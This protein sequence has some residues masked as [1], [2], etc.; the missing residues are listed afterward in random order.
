VECSLFVAAKTHP[1]L[2]RWFHRYVIF[3]VIYT[4]VSVL[5]I[6]YLFATPAAPTA[7]PV[8]LTATPVPPTATPAPP[9]AITL[10][11]DVIL[12]ITPP[13]DSQQGQCNW[14]QSNFP[15]TEDQAR[16][17]Y[18]LPPNTTILLITNYA[19]LLSMHFASTLH[20]LLT[21]QYLPMDVLILG[22]DLQRILVMWERL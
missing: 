15:Q 13:D 8:P 2:K 17:M 4:V 20:P 3:V 7:T 16:N 12:T 11:D 6:V 19:L 10:S 9:T 1:E 14:L 22:L 21:Y 18:N 5:A